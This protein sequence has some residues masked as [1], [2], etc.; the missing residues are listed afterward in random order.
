MVSLPMEGTQAVFGV[1]D[2]RQDRM[3]H[4]WLRSLPCWSSES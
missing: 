2:S 1:L 3:T 4:E